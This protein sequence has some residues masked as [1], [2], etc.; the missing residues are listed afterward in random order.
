MLL[1]GHFF[2]S[3]SCGKKESFLLL[4]SLRLR[5]IMPP[6]P[7]NT[8]MINKRSASTQQSQQQ[9]QQQQQQQRQWSH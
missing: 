2:F 9:Q 1:L 5:W 7:P 8:T 3:N 6:F 4:E